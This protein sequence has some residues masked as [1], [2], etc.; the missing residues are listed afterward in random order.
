MTCSTCSA[1]LL[2]CS[3]AVVP[4][5]TLGA[6]PVFVASE[7]GGWHRSAHDTHGWQPSAACIKL[8]V[9]LKCSWLQNRHVCFADGV[10]AVQSGRAV[11]FAADNDAVE[12]G[13]LPVVDSL[14]PLAPE[15][16]A[17]AVRDYRSE[18]SKQ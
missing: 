15:E 2:S 17:L 11:A 12:R 4:L 3:Y 5:A 1:E 9:L 7:A 14:I 10:E 16:W 8:H 6:Q 18:L 13:D